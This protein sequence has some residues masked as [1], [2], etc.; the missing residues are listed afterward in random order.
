M[1]NFGGAKFES[2]DCQPPAGFTK[3][4]ICSGHT[5]VHTSTG[6]EEQIR[7]RSELQLPEL[8][9]KHILSAYRYLQG[10]LGRVV[11]QELGTTCPR[12]AP[13]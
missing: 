10:L 2:C 8:R 12:V 1:A 13:F 3:A 6:K 7:G 11:L 9:P 4:S 5:R